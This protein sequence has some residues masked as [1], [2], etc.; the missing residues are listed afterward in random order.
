[1][2]GAEHAAFEV[3]RAF[4]GA[5]RDAYERHPIRL[6]FVGPSTAVVQFQGHVGAGT[7]LLGALASLVRELG[8]VAA[9]QYLTAPR[10]EIHAARRR[11]DAVSFWAREFEKRQ[12][13]ANAP[14]PSSESTSSRSASSADDA[15]GP[16]E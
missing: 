7:T 8:G 4:A 5:A 1:M 14:E 10:S 2:G 6:H 12:G 3:A 16:S 9:A 13:T 11:L 15:C